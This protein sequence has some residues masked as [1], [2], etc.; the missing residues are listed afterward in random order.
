MSQVSITA[1]R[2]FGQ[3][4]ITKPATIEIDGA[5]AGEA[6][7]GKAQAVEVAPGPHRLTMSFPYLGRK[8]VGTATIDLDLGEGQIVDV[9]YRSPWIVTNKGSLK[10]AAPAG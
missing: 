9:T 10:V 2:R 1:R 5:P 3:W 8:Q 6:R 7:W 4:L